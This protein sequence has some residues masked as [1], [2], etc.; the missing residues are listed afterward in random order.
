[1]FVDAALDESVAGWTFST[2][3]A[4]AATAAAARLIL[5]SEHVFG[6]SI[7]S[8]ADDVLSA[9]ALAKVVALNG[10]AADATAVARSATG[11]RKAV[12]TG[13]ALIARATRH[14]FL[15]RALTVEQIARGV[16][17]TRGIASA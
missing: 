10:N 15:T 12:I 5:E 7:A 8:S 13:R 6:A 16:D 17:G 2:G 14:A 4:A 11:E 1:M 3:A 9:R